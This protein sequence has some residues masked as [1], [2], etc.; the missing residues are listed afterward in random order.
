MPAGNLAPR[1]SIVRQ[2]STRGWPHISVNRAVSRRQLR[3]NESAHI[4][5]VKDTVNSYAGRAAVEVAIT[6]S[7]A[8]R[9][10]DLI[11]LHTASLSIADS[12]PQATD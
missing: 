2:P 9:S 3:L 12:S 11:Q 7:V 1:L 6:M 10:L 5:R 4:A 8:F